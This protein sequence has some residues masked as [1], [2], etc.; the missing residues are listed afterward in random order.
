MPIVDRL[1]KKGLIQKFRNKGL[2][3]MEE[4]ESIGMIFSFRESLRRNLENPMTNKINL[5]L[6]GNYKNKMQRFYLM[7]KNADLSE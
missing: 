5:I 6:L 7:Y 3:N 1:L 2:E 4:K